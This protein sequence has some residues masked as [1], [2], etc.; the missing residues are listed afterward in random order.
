MAVRRPRVSAAASERTQ[1]AN[2]SSV[3][4]TPI[5]VLYRGRLRLELVRD[6]AM[7]EWSPA[8]LAQ[9]L[10][11][12]TA[13][14]EAFAKTYAKDIDEVR[15]ALAGQ[16]AI[17]ASGLWITKKQNR[18]AELQA[19][20]DEINDV[21]SQMRLGTY[22]PTDNDGTNLGSRRH[23]ALLK[24]KMDIL[25]AVADELSPRGAA[26]G[27]GSP[28]DPNVVHYVIDAGTATEALR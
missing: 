18:I 9:R 14:I 16:L 28:D 13:D 22:R 26:S 5:T 4:A 17:E 20:F 6:L 21:L 11:V 23:R 27:V 2:K 19:D 3:G 8:S 25:S 12:D 7:G 15:Q 1:E 10:G 24:S